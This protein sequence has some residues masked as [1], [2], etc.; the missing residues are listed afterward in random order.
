MGWFARAKESNGAEPRDP[1]MQMARTMIEEVD[2][3]LSG[4]AE[5][6]GQLSSP[7]IPPWNRINRLA[8]ADLPALRRYQASLALLATDGHAGSDEEWRKVQ[9]TLTKELLG[10]VG[11]E[12][13][14]LRQIQRSSL[15]PLELSMIAGS[16]ASELSPQDLLDAGRAAMERAISG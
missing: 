5:A 16:A 1:V 2:A 13:D 14:L 3:F 8:H 11:D 15:I 12:G 9:W 7:T 10:L 6:Y 4:A